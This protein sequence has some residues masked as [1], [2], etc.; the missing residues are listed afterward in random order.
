MRHKHFAQ[1]LIAKLFKDE[2][3][4]TKRRIVPKQIIPQD[5]P[6]S[7]TEDWSLEERRQLAQK[8]LKAIKDGSAAFGA[9]SGNEA[10]VVQ[11]VH[12]AVLNI[13]VYHTFLFVADE[14][15]GQIFFFVDN[16][17]KKY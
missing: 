12:I 9:V 17:R 11:N 3:K 16:W 8:I 13:A 10:A 14:Q 1:T 5:K 4:G 15:Q 2:Q 7:Y 6:V